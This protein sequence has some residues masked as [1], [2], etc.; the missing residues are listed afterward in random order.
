M[1]FTRSTMKKCLGLGLILIAQLGF[2][3][4]SKSQNHNWYRYYDNKG[5]PTLSD[6]ISETHIRRGYEILNSQ[7]QVVRQVPAF[8]EVAYQNDKIKRDAAFK[9]QQEDARILRLYTSAFDAEMT[10]KRQLDSLE[11]GIGYN[12]IQLIRLKRFRADAVTEAAE[13][14]RTGKTVSAK[15]TQQVQQYD[16]QIA[17]VQKV[18]A[19]ARLEMD[20]VRTEFAPII[21]RLTELENTTKVASNTTNFVK[22]VAQP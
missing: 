19:A 11:T 16:K 9:Q 1:L 14:E 10:L 13:L 15:L 7:M 2:A 17:D 22:M 5:M 12:G 20:K 4:V 18:V 8:D 21:A 3:G 6:Q